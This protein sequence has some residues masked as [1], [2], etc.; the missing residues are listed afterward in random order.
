MTNSNN[1][2]FLAIEKTAND[3]VN[4]LQDLAKVVQ[5]YNEVNSNLKQASQGLFTM[6]TQYQDVASQVGQVAITM[7]QVG[8][9]DLLDAVEQARQ[10]TSSNLVQLLSAIEQAQQSVSTGHDNLLAS[11]KEATEQ[12]LTQQSLIY[13]AVLSLA[14]QQ[15]RDAA[16]TKRLIIVGALLATAAGVTA[17]VLPLLNLTL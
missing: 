4:Q 8:M 7:R 9:P 15:Q 10:E 14:N 6:T 16:Q 13:H 3:L 1:N 12:V 11:V 5:S 17:T 2:Q